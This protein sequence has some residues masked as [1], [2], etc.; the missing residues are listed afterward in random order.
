MMNKFMYQNLN[1]G[2]VNIMNSNST[3]QQHGV[4][5]LICKILSIYH[6]FT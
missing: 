6:P 3:F 4:S 5:R 1:L 2:L